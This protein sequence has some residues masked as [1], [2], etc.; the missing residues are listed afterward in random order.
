MKILK[1]KNK[2]PSQK[3]NRKKY[4]KLI[5]EKQKENHRKEELA[6]LF[7]IYEEKKDA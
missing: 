3:R 5:Y 7:G 4:E 2:L 6:F 1:W